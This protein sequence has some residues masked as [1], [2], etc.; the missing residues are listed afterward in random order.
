MGRSTPH[1][2]MGWEDYV[3][4]TWVRRRERGQ[5][6]VIAA[7]LLPVLLA[8]AGMAIDVGSYASERR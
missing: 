2:L 6:L 8:M 5:V 3:M 4:T 1:I 7:I